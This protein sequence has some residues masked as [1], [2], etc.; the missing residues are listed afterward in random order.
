MFVVSRHKGQKITIGEEIEI[1][2]LEVSKSVVK[3]GIVAPKST[4]ILRAEIRESIEQAN[5]QAA[6]AAS[7]TIDAQLACATGERPIVSNLEETLLPKTANA[8]APDV[9]PK[10]SD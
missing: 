1:V 2:V 6:D 9:T 7:L 8:L 5:R 3:L 4:P 10:S